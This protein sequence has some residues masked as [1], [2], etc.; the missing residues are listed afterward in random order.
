MEPEARVAL[1]WPDPSDAPLVL[2]DSDEEVGSVMGLYV[3]HSRWILDWPTGVLY[4]T[5][6]L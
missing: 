4:G 6:P 1:F 5:N 3:S 2:H